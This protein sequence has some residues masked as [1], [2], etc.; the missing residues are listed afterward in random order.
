MGLFFEVLSAINN[1]NQQGSV[2][3]LENIT[4][5][6]QKV[7]ADRGIE[8]SR[9]QS[10]L[11]VMGGFIR[12]ALQQN[13][14]GGSLSPNLMGDRVAGA[15]ATASAIQSLFPPQLQQQ[16]IQEVAQK[17]G[18]NAST[19]QGMLPSLLP[20]VMGILGMGASTSG[21]GGS[22]SLLNAFLDSDRDGDTDLGD[23]FKFANR[24]LNPPRY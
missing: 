13:L 4:T 21:A 22:N 11:S 6:I 8:S 24:F 3:Q 5:T 9:L 10:I 17:T 1:P 12:P 14:A 20:A 2:A 7:A 16:I 19:L 18:I 23:V 15:G